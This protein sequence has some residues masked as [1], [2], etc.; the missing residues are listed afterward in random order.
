[1]DSATATDPIRKG[2]K[3]D[4]VLAGA[5]TVFLRD[6][7]E[8]A[9]VD[10]I[11]REAGVSKA[12]LYSYF[13]D[14]TLMFLEMAL[15]ECRAQAKLCGSGVSKGTPIAEAL[16][17]AARQII[18]VLGSE[19]GR[20]VYRICLAESERFPELARAFYRSGR[21]A[22]AHDLSDRL[23]R[24]RAEGE[25]Q[26]ADIDFAV[27]QFME[28]CRAGLHER[29]VFGLSG[30]PSATEVDRTAD[31]AVEMFMARYGRRN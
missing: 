23:L 18:A 19:V 26:I 29:L 3:F 11:A 30:E 12:T 28:L 10:D 2:R 25:V 7:F 22:F 8:R 5:R 4:Q 20:K 6:G 21:A 24:A 27:E 9:S 31:G 1:M 14:K 17:A 16:A 13:P 15:T